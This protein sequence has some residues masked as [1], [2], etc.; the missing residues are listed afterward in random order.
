MHPSC[1]FQINHVA[2]M[3]CC[4]FSKKNR[5]IYITVTRTYHSMHACVAEFFGKYNMSLFPPK[6]QFMFRIPTVHQSFICYTYHAARMCC[7]IVDFFQISCFFL[8]I[9]LIHWSYIRT[10]SF[11]MRIYILRTYEYAYLHYTHSYRYM[12]NYVYMYIYIYIHV[13]IHMHIR[14]YMFT[15]TCKYIFIYKFTY[16]HADICVHEYM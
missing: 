11:Q 12:Q 4:I 8:G 6:T 5:C 16:I 13:Y 9:V 14:I 7:C 10:T 1:I 2:R 15:Y 3:C